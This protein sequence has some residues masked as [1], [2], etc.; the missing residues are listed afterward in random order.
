MKATL[1]K[2]S[3]HAKLRITYSDSG[4]DRHVDIHFTPTDD[5]GIYSAY[6]SEE[7]LNDIVNLINACK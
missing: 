1:E 5:P 3:D 4:Q 2:T 7:F 6:C